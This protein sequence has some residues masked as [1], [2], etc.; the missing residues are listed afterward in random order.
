M[1]FITMKNKSQHKSS[2]TKGKINTV[3]EL[4]PMIPITIAKCKG[5]RKTSRIINSVPLSRYS[6][7]KYKA[8]DN[9]I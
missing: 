7:P 5:K 6:V 4:P 8:R 1:S 9:K 3:T 2:R